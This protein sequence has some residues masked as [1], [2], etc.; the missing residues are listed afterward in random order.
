[1][2]IHGQYKGFF[3]LG[4]KSTCLHCTSSIEA[5]VLYGG[6]DAER[7][8]NF[9]PGSSEGVPADAGDEQDRP[10]V[11]WLWIGYALGRAETC[12]AVIVY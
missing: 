10:H 5:G 1:M 7:A 12:C 4:I 2:W 6:Y 9:T 8:R 3:K 11:Q